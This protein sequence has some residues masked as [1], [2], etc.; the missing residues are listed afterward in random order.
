[1]APSHSRDLQEE[2]MI[3]LLSAGPGLIINASAGALPLDVRHQVTSRV[4]CSVCSLF[5]EWKVKI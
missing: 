1:M 5:Q 4:T 2:E 3:S